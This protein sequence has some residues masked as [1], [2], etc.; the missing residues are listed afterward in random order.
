[1]IITVVGLGLIGGS[2]CKALKKNTDNV[3]YGIDNNRDTISLA[4]AEGSIDKEADISDISNTD[5]TVICLYPE[6]TIS[7]VLNNK[8]N[9]KKNSLVIDMCGV[10]EV[11]VE[12]ATE[13]LSSE[14]V[15]F[16]G[17]H[18]M[19]GREFSGFKYSVDDLF[20][21]SNF[22]ITPL[23][24]TTR[25]NIIIVEDF[26]KSIGA[27]RIIETSPENH[28]KMIAFT[29][30]LAHIVSNAYVKSP[31]ME[32]VKGYTAGSYKD[33]TRVAKL[34]PDMWTSLFMQNKGNLINEITSI[35][36]SL[37]EY[38]TALEADDENMLHQLLKDGSDIKE[39]S[40]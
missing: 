2:V 33:L 31:E 15:Y 29:S 36:E 27:T 25:E 12:K 13:I 30:Q 22:I 18:P 7:F 32:N 19:A 11:I 21:N 6:A 40:L 38:K 9:F 24:K 39:K 35:I 4:I 17:T 23:V 3:V 26:A 10:K 16:V 8:S 34:N 37:E 5:L 1:M 28:D 14:N 20:V